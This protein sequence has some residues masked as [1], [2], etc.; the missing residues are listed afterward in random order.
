MTFHEHTTQRGSNARLPIHSTPTADTASWA[1]EIGR[2]C[3]GGVDDSVHQYLKEIGQTPLLTAEQEI[4]LAVAI[5]DQAS[6]QALLAQGGQSAQER[7]RLE[8]Q[9]AQGEEARRLLIQAN[10]RL[11]VSIARRYL[12][13]GM[14]LMDLIQ[15]G[16]IGLIRVVEKFDHRKGNRFS[17]Y[18][19]WWIRQTIRRAI[20]NQSRTVRLP[21]RLNHILGQIRAAQSRLYQQLY[22]EPTVEELATELGMSADKIAA[23]LSVAE[24]PISLE[25]P[26]NDRSDSCLGDLIEDTRM[27]PLYEQVAGS[28]LHEELHARMDR[29]PARERTIIELRY[30]LTDGRPRTLDE[31]GAAFG[32]T[33]ERV[34]QLEVRAMRFLYPMAGAGVPHP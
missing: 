2:S 14:S 23:T 22:R 17:T 24:A 21:A 5:D 28:L 26:L 31:V 34:R 7:V 33:R 4:A 10:L 19:T 16:N 6:A 32:I 18:A 9:I 12:S 27:Q 13:S 3:Y 15:E 8:Q 1:A 30:G 25:S 20:E 29:M 11:V